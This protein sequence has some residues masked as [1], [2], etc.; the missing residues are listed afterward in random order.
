VVGLPCGD[1]V[2]RSPEPAGAGPHAC[3]FCGNPLGLELVDLGVS[4]L[5]ERFL[6]PDQL[7]DMEPFYP[8]RVEVCE[9]CFL[10][11]LPAYVPPEEI[12]LDYAYYSSYSVSW[13]AHASRYVEE[14]VSRRGLSSSSLVVEVGSNDGYLLRSFVARDIPVLGIEPARNVARAAEEQGVPTMAEFFGRSLAEDLVRSGRRADLL[15]GN[16]V[17]AQVPDLNDFVAGLAVL[18]ADDGLLTIEVPHLL[19]LM[20]GNQFDTIYHEHFS[21]FSMLALRRIFAAHGLAVVDVERLETHGGS[22]RLHIQHAG[23]ATE[24]PRVAAVV[25]EELKAGMGDP[26]GYAAFA[27]RASE[28]K[29]DL[30]TFLIEQHRRGRTIAA[31]GAPG[32]AN[33]FLNFC[34]V[35]RDLLPFIVDRNPYKHGRF[36]PGTRIPIY[37]VDALTRARPDYVW[38]LPWNLRD[39]VIDQL[40]DDVSS[41][42]GAFIVAIPRLEIVEAKPSRRRPS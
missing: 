26:S 1:A 32:K 37:A 10:A 34:G 11:Q 6:R 17:L 19:H 16:N 36:T 4:P 22:L 39:E 3:R 20:Q 29:R 33:T 8:L 28:V 42:A 27:A 25:D 12:F 41:W 7:D 15:V 23:R 30:L 2:E 24:G 31:Y 35:R 5:C 38:I 13:L 40:R 18:L 9:V 14:M 21:Y